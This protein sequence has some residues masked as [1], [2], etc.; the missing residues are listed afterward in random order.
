MAYWQLY[1][2]FVWATKE[3]RPFITAELEPDLHQYL[4]GKGLDLGGIVHAVGGIEEHVH[5]AVSIPPRLAVATFV[6]K[7]KGASSHWV[8]HLSGHPDHFSWQQG[9]GAISFSKRALP[10]VVDYVLNQR[11]R[12]AA[13]DLVLAMERIETEDT[14]P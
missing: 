2:H 12:H 4:R 11:Q 14:G 10:Q 9:Y 8:N 7:L 13:Q 1:Y 3:R 6:G 5:I